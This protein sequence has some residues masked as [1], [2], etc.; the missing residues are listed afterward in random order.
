MKEILKSTKS[1]ASRRDPSFVWLPSVLSFK[2]KL[3]NEN[4]EVRYPFSRE[5]FLI[6]AQ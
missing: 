1:A 5:H 4:G 2:E 3:N 6:T